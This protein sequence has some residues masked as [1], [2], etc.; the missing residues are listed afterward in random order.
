MQSDGYVDKLGEQYNA[1]R[2]QSDQD[3]TVYYRFIVEVTGKHG[4][5]SLV[6]Y[7]IDASAAHYAVREAQRRY[8]RATGIPVR[9][10]DVRHIYNHG[11]VDF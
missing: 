2:S 3:D 7:R 11:Y 4:L 9:D 10:Q 8:A 6:F 1:S 5:C